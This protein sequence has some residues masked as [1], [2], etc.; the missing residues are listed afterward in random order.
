MCCIDDP[1]PYLVCSDSPKQPPEQQGAPEEKIDVDMEQQK[2]EQ[3]EKE[4]TVSEVRIHKW[5]HDY[6]TFHL[7]WYPRKYSCMYT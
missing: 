5:H 2:Q 3:V 1:I 6:S 4:D 7:S